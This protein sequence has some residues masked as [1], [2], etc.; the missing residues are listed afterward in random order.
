MSPPHPYER[1]RGIIERVRVRRGRF[2]PVERAA[3]G[4]ALTFIEIRSTHAVS[5]WLPDRGAVSTI[6]KKTV[7]KNGLFDF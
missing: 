2:V 6:F 5:R 3:S 4:R 7:R 1:A